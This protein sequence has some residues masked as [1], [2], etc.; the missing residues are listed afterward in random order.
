[1]A[2]EER[3]NFGKFIRLDENDPELS[4]ASGVEVFAV[5]APATSELALRLLLEPRSVLVEHDVIDHHEG[6][7][8]HIT[9]NRV[10]AQVPIPLPPHKPPPKPPPKGPGAHHIVVIWTVVEESKQAHGVLYRVPPAEG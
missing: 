4:R 5:S 10:N 9:L 8:W 2:S 1:M 3:Q 7:G 6:A